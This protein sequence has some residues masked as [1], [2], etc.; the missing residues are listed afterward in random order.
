MGS[1]WHEPLTKAV[2]VALAC[3]A[4]KPANG[5]LEEVMERTRLVKKYL[6][7]GVCVVKLAVANE[8]HGANNAYAL[9]PYS[10]AIG[11]KGIKKAAVFVD[12]PS[13]KEIV[14]TQVNKIPIIDAGSV[15]EVK[16]NATLANGYI[17][18]GMGENL[19]KS[20]KSREPHFMI[21]AG[22]ALLKFLECCV[23]PALLDNA[24]SHWHLDA[25][26]AVAFAILSLATLEEA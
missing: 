21:G 23:S 1:A 8:L 5:F 7:N 12:E 10:L 16:V 19:H 6:G 11:G 20:K 18:L 15:V 2:G 9:F 13:A 22:Y 17:M 25:K 24:A 26:K 3:F 4:E 14:A